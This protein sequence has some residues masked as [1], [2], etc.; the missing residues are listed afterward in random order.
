MSQHPAHGQAQGLAAALTL[1]VPEPST[2]Q[3]SHSHGS[4]TIHYNSLHLNQWCQ[5]FSELM[6]FLL[7]EKFLEAETLK[8]W[9]F[10]ETT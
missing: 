1:W 10:L 4:G 6:A 7:K 5:V 2:R 3:I 9:V 8:A